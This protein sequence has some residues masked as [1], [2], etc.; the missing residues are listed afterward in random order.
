ML[1]I[2]NSSLSDYEII[3]E[4]GKG[5]FSTVYLVK[6]KITQKEFALKKVNIIIK[7]I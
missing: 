5:S 4:I 6:K 3:K 2:Q 7:Y 1:N